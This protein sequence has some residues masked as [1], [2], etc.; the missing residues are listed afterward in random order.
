MPCFLLSFKK[1]PV[2]HNSNVLKVTFKNVD[3]SGVVLTIKFC[4]ALV[5][6]A[7]DFNKTVWKANPNFIANFSNWRDFTII[8]K[9]AFSH[10]IQTLL[11]PSMTIQ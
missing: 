1:H 2:M 11:I 4:N 8:I 6:F 9:I 5:P 3:F 10:E 7:D